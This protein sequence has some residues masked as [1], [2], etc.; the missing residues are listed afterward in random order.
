VAIF[1]KALGN[2]YAI[3]AIIGKRSVMESIKS[4]FVSSTFWTERIGPSAALATLKIM[5][6]IKSWE[7]ISNIGNKI[8]KNWR[9]IADGSNVKINIYGIEAIPNFSFESEYNLFF[10]TFITQEMLKNKIL[11]SNSVYCCIEHDDKVLSKYFDILNKLFLKIK[12]MQNNKIN[13]NNF[14]NSPVCIS[15]FREIK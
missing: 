11:A 9:K 6:N 10:K 12:I 7:I 8:S 4:T 1:G 13:M 5:E 3:N 14:L 15:G 2:G